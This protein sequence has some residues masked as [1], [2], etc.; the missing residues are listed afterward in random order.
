MSRKLPGFGL[1]LGIVLFWLSAIVV[2]PLSA[3]VGKSLSLPW[4]GWVAILL[5]ARTLSAFRVS[6]LCSLAAAT[7]NAVMGTVVAWILVRY[8][9]PGK[10]ILDAMVDMPFAL[11]TAVAG[12]TLTSLWSPHGWL[13]A[14]LA[15]L[16]I[17]V[18]YTP[19]GIMLALAFVGLP[20]AV[21]TVQ[22]VLEEL[23]SEVEEAAGLLGADRLQTIRRVILPALR[24]AILAGFALS[25]ARGL[26][27]YGSVVFISGNLPGRTEIVPLLV[28]QRLEEFKAPQAAV[29]GVGMLALSFL[30]LLPANW[31]QS[32]LRRGR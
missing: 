9:F 4:D 29:L 22:P 3:L 10:R 26:G 21:R 11:P 17:R 14:P 31:L 19:L 2:V 32:R 24:P 8:E 12:I 28:M 20:F 27:E 25:F 13:G 30:F 1:S 7:L 23:P 16:G 6:L 15:E 5:D 18:A